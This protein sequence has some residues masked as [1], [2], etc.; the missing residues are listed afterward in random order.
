MRKLL[1]FAV[2]AALSLAWTARGAGLS[3]DE[4]AF[5]DKHMSDIVKVEPSRMDEPALKKVFDA[6]FFDVK[7][8]IN[9]GGSETQTSDVK[10]ARVGQELVN[11]SLPSTTEQMPKLK[12]M[13]KP[14][15]K[16]RSEQDAKAVEAALDVLY[17]IS[18]SFGGEDLK[19]KA[20]KHAGNKWMF[21]RG[22][23]FQ[24]HKGFAF[25]TGADGAITAVEY[26]LDLP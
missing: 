7:V 13:F 16:L 19:A 4:R 14:T 10:V 9:Q 22:A 25:T 11:V 15:F 23:F 18:N 17:P 21:I 20:I 24:K 12:Q 3:A 5:F 8:T 2:V 26:S 1:A 6:P